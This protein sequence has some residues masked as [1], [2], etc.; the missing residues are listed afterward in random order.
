MPHERP[1]FVAGCPAAV[2]LCRDQGGVVRARVGIDCSATLPA[3]RQQGVDLDVNSHAWRAFLGQ[4]RLLWLHHGHELGIG[5]VKRVAVWQHGLG[6]VPLGF[7][8]ERDGEA[9]NVHGGLL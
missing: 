5:G 9:L 1:R 2:V 3:P 7:S 8:P 4:L 6:L